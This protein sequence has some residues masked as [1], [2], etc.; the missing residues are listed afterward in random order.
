M[1]KIRPIMRPPKEGTNVTLSKARAA[2]RE[3]N[4]EHRGRG[5]KKVRAPEKTATKAG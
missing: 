2:L 5:K 4:R 1:D 3:L